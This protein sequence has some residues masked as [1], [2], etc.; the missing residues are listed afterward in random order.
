MKR[1]S[2]KGQ[3]PRIC[4]DE[5]WWTGGSCKR[6]NDKGHDRDEVNLGDPRKSE[7]PR[8]IY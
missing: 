6:Q 2:E 8:K 5:K 3:T 7:C 1:R 4:N